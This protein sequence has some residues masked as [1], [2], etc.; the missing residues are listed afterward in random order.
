[1]ASRWLW[2]IPSSVALLPFLLAAMACGAWDPAALFP[3]VAPIFPESSAP[4]LP[5]LVAGLAS[6]GPAPLGSPLQL[7]GVQI[8]VTDFIRKADDIVKRAETSPFI[9]ADKQFA[10]VEISVTC[11]AGGGGSCNVTE[12]NFSLSGRSAPTVYPELGLSFSGLRGLFDGGLMTEGTSLSG[13]LV[14]ILD[15]SETDLVL[16][17]FPVP[18]FGGARATFTLGE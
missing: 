5:D 8:S 17:Y 16:S 2:R 12:F 9:D 3:T 18:G 14:F 1:M 13:S 10:L 4:A 7:G 15:R 11:L 6:V